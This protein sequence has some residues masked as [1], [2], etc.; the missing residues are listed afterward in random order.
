MVFFGQGDWTCS[1]AIFT[2]TFKGTMMGLD[3]KI[4]QPT[5]KEFRIKFCTVAHWKN[6]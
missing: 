5:N 2:G 1:V 4:I 3:G 6:G